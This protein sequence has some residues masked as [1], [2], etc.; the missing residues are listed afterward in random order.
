MPPGDSS[1]LIRLDT[2]GEPWV[3]HFEGLG[4]VRV[5]DQGGLTLQ[6]ITTDDPSIEDALRWGWGELLSLRRRGFTLIFAA[7]AQRAAE[8]GCL[9]ISGAAHEV[10]RVVVALAA[11]SW[12][13]LSDRTTPCRWDEGRLIA[14][15]TAAP[16]VAARRRAELAGVAG[17]EIRPG[18]DVVEVTAT[19]SQEPIE[20]AAIL[21]V[22][23]RAHGRSAFELTSGRARFEM[24]RTLMVGGVLGDT[25]RDEAL[26]MH[27]A[28][29]LATLP[30]AELRLDS[31]TQAEDIQDALRM[32]PA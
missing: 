7:A 2:D 3:G 10:G 9:L 27:D 17:R 30:I 12:L 14:T 29:R 26:Q 32:W 15:P 25:D 23:V 20:V 31:T 22:P 8:N 21:R 19:R 4:N 13:F 1:P 24:V 16:I 5:D 6:P 28:M 18:S 11:Q